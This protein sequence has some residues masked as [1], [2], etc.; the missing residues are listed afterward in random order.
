[1]RAGLSGMPKKVSCRDVPSPSTI[2]SQL[3]AT[4]G[5]LGGG[6]AASITASWDGAIPDVNMAGDTPSGSLPL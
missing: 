5:R 2:A 4:A 6:D 3:T 1:M